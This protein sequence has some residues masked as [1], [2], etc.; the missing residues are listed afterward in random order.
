MLNISLKGGNNYFSIPQMQPH[1]RIIGPLSVE[2]QYYLFIS[3]LVLAS[4]SNSL[5]AIWSWHSALYYRK[6]SLFVF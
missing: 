5:T 4:C 3:C 6:V 1:L 2:E